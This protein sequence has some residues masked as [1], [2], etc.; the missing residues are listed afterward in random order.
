MTDLLPDPFA[1]VEGGQP[2]ATAV[3][4]TKVRTYTAPDPQWASRE[5]CEAIRQRLWRMDPR[6]NLWW[7]P[8]WPL[9]DIP[10]ERG[11]WAIMYWLN[12]EQCWS[13]V[14]YHE[15]PTGEYR[16]LDHDCVEHFIR[17]LEACDQDARQTLAVIQARQEERKKASRLHLEDAMRSFGREVRSF[18]GAS[19]EKGQARR[20]R[21]AQRVW[22]A[23]QRHMEDVRKEQEE[24]RASLAQ[25]S[26]GA[27][28]FGPG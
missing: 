27:Q 1:P 3:H 8:H 5:L 16:P 20:S 24:R 23:R 19:G 6:L 22:E 25:R 21:N 10:R 2:G 12:G 26:R 11:R 14:F 4:P 15:G 18:L 28:E 7:N 17:R 13:V 9:T